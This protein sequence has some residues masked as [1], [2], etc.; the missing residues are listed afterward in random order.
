MC[1]AHARTS[2]LPVSHLFAAS[3][4]AKKKV[5]ATTSETI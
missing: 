4:V 3:F 1:D 5:L 2:S